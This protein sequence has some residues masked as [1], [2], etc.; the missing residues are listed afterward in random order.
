MALLDTL[1]DMTSIPGPG[2]G[3][4]ST[5]L[6]EYVCRSSLDCELEPKNIEW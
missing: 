4:G 6:Y 2:F 1:V 5:A 3:V